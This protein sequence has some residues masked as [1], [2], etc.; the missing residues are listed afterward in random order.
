[1]S[2]KNKVMSD[3][4]AIV[5]SRKSGNE[6]FHKNSSSI[7]VNLL[8]FWQWSSSD[9]VGNALRGVLAEYIVASD[10]GCVSDLRQEWDA[11]DLLTMEGIKIEVKSCAY[12][13]SWQ[14]DK[15]SSIS[16]GIQKTYGWDAEKNMRISIKKRQADVYV[17]CVLSHKDQNTIDPMNVAQWEFY[18]LATS[19]LN[20][21]VPE[22]KSIT[23]SSLKKLNPIK[24]QY[25]DIYTTI[26]SQISNKS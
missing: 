4:Q 1:M 16:F 13:Q 22:Q 26:K 14:Q 21:E 18:I 3:L 23:L 20:R 11:Y 10:I 15:Y 25:G 24:T 9:L 17:F 6:L 8:S 7:G 12:I 5:V 2:E 19:V